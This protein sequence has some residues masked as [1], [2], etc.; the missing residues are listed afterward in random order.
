MRRA[1]VFRWWKLFRDG[2]TNVKDEPRSGRPS[3]APV[4]LPLKLAANDLQYVVGAL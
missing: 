4:S 3:T 2:E 1:A